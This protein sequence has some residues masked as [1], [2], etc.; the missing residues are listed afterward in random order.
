MTDK[1]N[2]S[3]EIEPTEKGARA[4]ERLKERF[5]VST[6]P[7]GLEV[8]AGSESGIN[9]LYMNLNRQLAAGKLEEKIKL[10]A[11]IGV[12]SATGSA[13]ATEFFAQA[14]MAKGVEKQEALDA[15]SVAAV[16]AI[17]N[18]YYRFRHQVPAEMESTYANF[19]AP[20][21]A[22]TFMKSGLA[23]IEVEAICIAV[24]SLNNCHACVEG[25]INKGKSLGLTDE[26]IDE[27]IKVTAAVSAASQASAALAGG[28]QAAPAV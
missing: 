3:L 14:A 5:G 27:L 22:N 23:G 7:G 13:D 18:G 17:F 10:L 4:L 26:Q 9:D 2:S 28:M 19:R 16:C 20:F 11:A 24:S 21:N 1:G 25:H 12:A 8:L 6:L 15:V